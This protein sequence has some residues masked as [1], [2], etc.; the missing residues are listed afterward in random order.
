MGG[1]LWISNIFDKNL[2]VKILNGIL[3][4]E[5]RN[6]EESKLSIQNVNHIKRFFEI[7]SKE[8]DQI[9]YHYISDEFGKLMKN[10]TH[11]LTKI[12]DKLTMDGYNTSQTIFSSTGFKTE[13]NLQEIKSSLSNL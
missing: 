13:A 3:E 6:E 1:P 2:I 7:A 12:I 4:S 11:P 10:S 9:P 5:T 8:L